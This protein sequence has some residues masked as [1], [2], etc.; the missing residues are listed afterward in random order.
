MLLLL[1]F[2]FTPCYCF[3]SP[4]TTVSVNKLGRC[5]LFPV[6]VSSLAISVWSGIL[7]SSSS[8][9]SVNPYGKLL[10]PISELLDL[11]LP[12]VDAICQSPW[13]KPLA[14]YRQGVGADGATHAPAGRHVHRLVGNLTQPPIPNPL[15]PVA[16]PGITNKSNL[17]PGTTNTN[18]TNDGNTPNGLTLQQQAQYTQAAYQQQ[19]KLVQEKHDFLGNRPSPPSLLSSL[20]PSPSSH[21]FALANKHLICFITNN[22]SISTLSMFLMF[23]IHSQ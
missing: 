18:G 4:S 15:M 6:P 10:L 14:Y 5:A 7:S 23:S 8:D 1:L 21:Y 11:T 22:Q 13:P 2:V 17:I 9:L 3:L 20:L 16:N 19:M 12:P